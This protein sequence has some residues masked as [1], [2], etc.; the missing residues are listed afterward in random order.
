MLWLA[1][2]YAYVEWQLSFLAFK[3]EGGQQKQAAKASAC[4]AKFNSFHQL[5]IQHSHINKKRP[6][7]DEFRTFLMNECSNSY[8]FS[9][10]QNKFTQV[11]M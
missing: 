9:I 5:Y 8:L 4:Y 7:L 11:H 3:G 10:I 1:Q 2:L 6:Q